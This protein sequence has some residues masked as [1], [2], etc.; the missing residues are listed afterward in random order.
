MIYRTPG[1][2]II[3]LRFCPDS[4]TKLDLSEDPK[5]PCKLEPLHYKKALIHTPAPPLTSFQPKL[6]HW[7]GICKPVQSCHVFFAYLDKNAKEK[8][9]EQIL[10][11][12]H[13]HLSNLTSILTEQD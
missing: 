5:G 12:L 4:V 3:T 8:K 1:L 2:G 11:I 7:P 6:A 9:V 13:Q 10:G